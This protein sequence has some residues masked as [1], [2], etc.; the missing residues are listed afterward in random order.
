MG[1]DEI[2]IEAFKELDQ[3]GKELLLKI[4]NEWWESEETEIPEEVSRARIALT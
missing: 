2:P 3:E 1:P 4:I